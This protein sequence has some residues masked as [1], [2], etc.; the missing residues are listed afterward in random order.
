[1][2]KALRIPKKVDIEFWNKW[3]YR[4]DIGEPGTIGYVVEIRDRVDPARRFALKLMKPKERL[5]KA[6]KKEVVILKQLG[7][8]CPTIMRYH[9]VLYV[10]DPRADR[11]RPLE[12]PK[13][14]PA[15]A[16]KMDLIGGQDLWVWKKKQFKKMKK[17]DLE[18][19]LEIQNAE[20]VKFFR[21]LILQI[22]QQLQ[23]MHNLGY[24]HRDIKPENILHEK[25]GE[26][27]G[28]MKHI[29]YLIDFD[30]ACMWKKP[31]CQ[32]QAG[33]TGF[34]PPE[35]LIPIDP[36]WDARRTDIWAFGATLYELLQ[37]AQFLPISETADREAIEDAIFAADEEL[38]KIDLYPANTTIEKLV[39]GMLSIEPD[40]R[41]EAI[42]LVKAME[43][44][45]I[46]T[47]ICS[48]C[49]KITSQRC[50]DCNIL[51]C[52]KKCQ[53]EGW[54]THQLQCGIKSFLNYVFVVLRV[55]KKD[56][57]LIIQNFNMN[58][59]MLLLCGIKWSLYFVSM[60]HHLFHCSHAFLFNMFCL[61][62]GKPMFQKLPCDVD[63][64]QC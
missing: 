34:L 53:E 62:K 3:Q 44:V 28:G 45:Q 23:C 61:L 17:R 55:G 54:P 24:A 63:Y 11:K 15:Y 46:N 33:T 31:A 57:I 8:K 26:H 10:P 49:S 25:K 58:I 32:G 29:F 18:Y 42:E 64:R 37:D 51:Y 41:P 9:D 27:G 16:I 1:M 59:R 50:G 60:S 52:S 2:A 19:L 14:P 36:I 38:E 43:K 12:D 13:Y 56:L 30:Q 47:N 20:F 21:E 22:G 40:D 35:M 5:T 6:L 48:M 7:K 39:R 4:R